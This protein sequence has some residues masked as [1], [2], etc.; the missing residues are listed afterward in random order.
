MINANLPAFPPLIFLLASLLVALFGSLKRTLGYPIALGAITLGWV[1]SLYS[2]VVV[3]RDGTIHYHLGGWLPPIGIEYVLDPLSAFMLAVVTT[4]A[5][6]VML[7][8][9]GS[10]QIELKGKST[11]YFAVMMLLMAGV[12]GILVTGDVFNLFVFLEIFSLSTYALIAVGEK[13][14]PVAAFRYLLLGTIGA[15]M[16]LLG[17]GFIFVK[18]GS[19]NMADLAQIVPLLYTDPVVVVGVALIVVGIGIKM[20][21]FPLHGWLP[22]AYTYAP[23]ASSAMIAPIGTKIAAYI[24]IRILFFV[25]TP[26]FVRDQLPILHIVAWLSAGGILYGSIMA[27]AQ[28]ELKRMLS[29]SSV[30]QIG[31]I[32]LG[33]GLGSTLGLISALFHVL[34]HAFMK[35]CLFLVAGNL[36]AK[37]GHSEIPLFDTSLKSRMP[38]TMAAFTIAA[39]SMIGVPPTAGFF[40]KWYLAVASIQASHQP[41]I[42][43]AAWIFLTVILVSSLLNAVYFFRVIERVYI[44]RKDRSIAAVVDEPRPSMLVPTLV[45]AAGLLILGILNAF[46]VNGILQHAVPFGLG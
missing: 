37:I 38:W 41:G 29:Y 8:A 6:L 15:S 31:Y 3:L 32:G 45:L 11:A 27:I 14:A 12:C 16:Y 21:L 33:I 28:K 2:V 40:S 25:F 30:A 46:V 5:F 24:L 19:L 34:N 26:A 42:G 20:A 36:R 18:S 13:P 43:A 22:D 9:R 7:S 10:V 1:S 23:S 39:L 44:A 17:V 4:V 35:S